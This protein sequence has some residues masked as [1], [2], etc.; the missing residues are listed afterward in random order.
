MNEYIPSYTAGF[1]RDRRLLI[2]RGYAM[3]K[4]E[5]TIDLLLGGQPMPPKYRDHPLKGDWQGYRE[6][7]V[8]GL[9]NWLLI[10]RK[11]DENLILVFT[12]TG[13]HADLFA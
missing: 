6:C 1:R 11:D 5:N 3:P 4:L 2:K 9:G 8:E 13:T 12:G 10:Y 7:H